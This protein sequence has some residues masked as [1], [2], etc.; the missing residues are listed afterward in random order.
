M[1]KR[2][3]VPVDLAH[4]S[5]LEK[6]LRLARD[7]AQ[8]YEAELCYVG[9]TTSTPS[10]VSRTPEEFMRKLQA[11]AAEQAKSS[12]STASTHTIVSHDPTI[13]MDRELEEAID[14]LGADLVVMASHV[15]NVADYVWS[16][17]GAHIAAHSNAS[18]ML[19]RD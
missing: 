7:L 11:F 1:F 19:V 9:V 3:V 14:E 12:Q 6:A 10:A 17:H 2:I 4:V 13:Q 5:K 15:P 16:G 8:K 18:V